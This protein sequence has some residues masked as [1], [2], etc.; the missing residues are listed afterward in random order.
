MVESSLN[1]NLESVPEMNCKFVF[2]DI[3]GKHVKAVEHLSAKMISI[4]VNDLQNGVY[5]LTI[6][7]DKG[8]VQKTEKIIKK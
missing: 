2:Y 3:S 8:M 7:N 4:D 1:I 6:L 5:F